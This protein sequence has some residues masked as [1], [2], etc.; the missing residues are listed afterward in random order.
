V[1]LS[2]DFDQPTAPEIDM[3]TEAFEKP[4]ELKLSS[5]A[6][7]TDSEKYDDEKLLEPI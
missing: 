5:G 2:F 6:L 7:G 4:S 1:V 3:L